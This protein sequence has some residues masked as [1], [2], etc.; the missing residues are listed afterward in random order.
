MILAIGMKKNRYIGTSVKGQKNKKQNKQCEDFFVY[1]AFGKKQIGIVSD[2]AGSA[3]YAKIG[4]QVV[5]NTLIDVLSSANLNNVKEK[6][7]KAIE[8]SRDKLLCHRFCKDKNLRDFS[9][10]MIGF[11][12]HNNQGVMFHIGDGAA[13]GLDKENA[14]TLSYPHN[15][16]FSCETF[17]Y[18]MDDWRSHLRFTSCKKLSSIFLMT[19]GISPFALEGGKLRDNFIIP[20]NEFLKSEKTKNQKLKCL[21]NTFDNDKVNKLNSDD[22]TLLW[23]EL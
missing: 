5:C 16:Y 21:E 13:I 12:Y 18:T 11:F 9:A 7:V 10:T 8:I 17:F 1:K 2:G 6:V 15:G 19:D 23:C 4:A 22:K 14:I 3:K 20:I